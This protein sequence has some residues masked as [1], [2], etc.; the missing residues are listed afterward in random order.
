MCKISQTHKEL[1]LQTNSSSCLLVS[2]CDIGRAFRQIIHYSGIDK[3]F[4]EEYIQVR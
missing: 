2:F 4:L 1:G 3:L